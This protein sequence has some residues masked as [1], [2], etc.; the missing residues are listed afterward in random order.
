MDAVV[1]DDKQL[2]REL[3]EMYLEP[4]KCLERH[5]EMYGREVHFFTHCHIKV[6]IAVWYMSPDLIYV[7]NCQVRQHLKDPHSFKGL[8]L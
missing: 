6:R 8:W 2:D 4:M 5:K 1:M 3:K 7:R